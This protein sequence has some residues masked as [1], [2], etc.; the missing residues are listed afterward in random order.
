MGQDASLTLRWWIVADPK[1]WKWDRLFVDGNVRFRYGKIGRHYP[2]LKVGD[3][4]VGYESASATRLVA[5]ARVSMAFH[6]DADGNQW[7]GL[8]PVARITASPS[9]QEMKADTILGKSEPI[10]NLNRGI[11]FALTREESERILSLMPPAD[12]HAANQALDSTKR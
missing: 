7:F 11:L 5:I 1:I 3:I 2:L 12:V 10:R 8:E 4:V 6:L 9:F